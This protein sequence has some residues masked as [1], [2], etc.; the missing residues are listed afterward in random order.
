MPVSVSMVED[1]T[2][3]GMEREQHDYTDHKKLMELLRKPRAN[4]APTTWSETVT[5]DQCVR[6]FVDLDFKYHLPDEDSCYAMPFENEEDFDEK[7]LEGENPNGDGWEAHQERRETY[8][9]I[10]KTVQ[11]EL[12][13]HLRGRHEI[14]RCR[15]T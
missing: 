11:E 6:L 10:A 1:Y 15:H 14:S 2:K 12:V 5:A 9:R 4:K 3:G 7:Y 8:L 13:E